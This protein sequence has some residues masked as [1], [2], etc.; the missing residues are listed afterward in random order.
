LKTKNGI[1][2]NSN[3]ARIF[4]KACQKINFQ[5]GTRANAKAF[6]LFRTKNIRQNKKRKQPKPRKKKFNFSSKKIW[7]FD[8]VCLPCVRKKG[9]TLERKTIFFQKK[10]PNKGFATSRAE[11]L[12]VLNCF[13]CTFVRMETVVL[14]SLPCTNAF[15]LQASIRTKRQI[16]TLTKN[17]VTLWKTK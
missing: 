9:K 16:M 3:Q 5:S 11:V 8:F 10:T 12:F 4:F 14:L 17:F 7:K 6:S 2:R 1:S 15:S 13:F